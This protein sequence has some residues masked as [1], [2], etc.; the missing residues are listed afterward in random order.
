MNTQPSSIIC[1]TTQVLLCTSCLWLS[2]CYQSCV[3]QTGD[4]VREQRYLGQAFFDNAG[5]AVKVTPG[6][7][8]INEN[9]AETTTFR[10][11][12]PNPKIDIYM[13]DDVEGQLTLDL[14]NVH[15]DAQISV[16]AVEQLTK[17]ASFADFGLLENTDN[18][19]VDKPAPDPDCVIS[20]IG[21]CA[22]PVFNH[23]STNRTHAQLTIDLIPCRRYILQVELP[24]AQQET[25]LTYAVVGR[26]ANVAQ[27]G[28][29]LN[30]IS[31]LGVDF[32][33]FLGNSNQ[34]GEDEQLV[35]LQSV[36]DRAEVTVVMLPGSDEVNENS[37]LFAQMFGAFDF[38]WTFKRT[39][40]VVFY[41]SLGQIGQRGVLLLKNYLTAMSNED[42]LA[43]KKEGLEV[44]QTKRWP[45]FAF[46]HTPPF[47]PNGLQDDGLKSRHEAARVLSLLAQYDIHTLFAGAKHQPAQTGNRPIVRVTSATS[48]VAQQG[49][50]YLVVTLSASNVE[51]STPVGDKF[52]RVETRVAPK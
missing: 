3:Q 10:A 38:R 28:T 19:P 14:L 29:I 45:A 27:L 47:D 12:V 33:V 17:N 13:N 37:S 21:E 2:A 40:F 24:E 11:S 46:T 16:Q 44:A 23:K 22:P 48:N 8:R 18:C 43:Q 4:R 5:V 30:E 31:T 52:M 34:N 41:S 25:E 7:V 26:T 20:N 9:G 39:Q 42:Q 49:D 35:A 15:P 1:R 32:V 36:I 50:E 51:G 6:V